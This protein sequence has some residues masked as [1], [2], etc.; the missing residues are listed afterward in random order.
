MVSGLAALAQTDRHKH[1]QVVLLSCSLRS[2]WLWY[3]DNGLMAY[4]FV[5]GD[6]LSSEEENQSS[7]LYTEQDRDRGRKRPVNHLN[8]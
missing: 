5:L 2:H 3:R 7:N 1:Q 8:L 6:H 4:A